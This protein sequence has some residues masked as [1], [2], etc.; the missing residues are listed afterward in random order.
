MICNPSPTGLGNSVRSRIDFAISVSRKSAEWPGNQIEE[1]AM[2]KLG[3]SMLSV[4]CLL[5]AGQFAHAADQAAP[6]AVSATATADTNATR[7]WRASET[8]GMAVYNS[9]GDK[10]GKVEDL[11][12]DPSTGHIR[13]AVLSFGGFLGIGDKYFA[14]PMNHMQVESKAGGITG[15]EKYHFVLN[16]DKDRLK[17]APGFD[18]KNWPDFGDAAYGT[19]V[20]KFYG[21]PNAGGV[22]QP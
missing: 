19:S 6:L 15:A 9:A 18:S 2:R 13:Y 16:V 4:A 22:R 8:I 5:G 20:D 21:T 1:F 3:V 14:I 11:V 17:N 12:F 10:L 7:P